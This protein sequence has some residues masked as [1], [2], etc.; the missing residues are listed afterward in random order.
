MTIEVKDLMKSIEEID[1][2]IVELT[3]QLSELKVERERLM[4]EVTKL[5][6]KPR[7]DIIIGS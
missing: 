2:L 6:M 1:E 5:S 4:V 7:G 3:T